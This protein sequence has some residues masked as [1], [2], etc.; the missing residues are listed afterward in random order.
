M[1]D[2]KVK[3]LQKLLKYLKILQFY[4]LIIDKIHYQ[5][6]NTTAMIFTKK[7]C[8]DDRI[9]KEMH[10]GVTQWQGKGAYTNEDSLILVTVISKYEIS[11]LKKI[12]KEIDPKAFIIFNDGM[13]VTGNFEKRL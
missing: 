7:K 8:I 9:M 3:S 12:V 2:I 13:D 4:S 6:I 5:N 10:R 1:L 11:Q